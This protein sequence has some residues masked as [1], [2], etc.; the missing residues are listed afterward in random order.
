MYSPDEYA[1]MDELVG[2]EP[3]SG[4]NNE[5]IRFESDDDDD[6]DDDDDYCHDHGHDHAG[7]D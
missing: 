4:H 5:G 2:Q 6:D 7:D 3:K 1:Q